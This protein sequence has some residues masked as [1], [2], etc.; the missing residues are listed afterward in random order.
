MYAG[1]SYVKI[2]GVGNPPINCDVVVKTRLEE[3]KQR[4]NRRSP[5][6]KKKKSPK[7]KAKKPKKKSLLKE[8]LH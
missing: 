2:W 6:L 1:L 7:A 4:E 3:L 8:L 5:I